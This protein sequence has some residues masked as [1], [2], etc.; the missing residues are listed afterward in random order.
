MQPVLHGFQIGECQLEL[1]DAEVFQWVG[2]PGDVV[3]LEGAEDEHDRVDLA[4]VGQELV[5]ESLTLAGALDETTDVDHLYGGMDD[6]LARRHHGQ[7][8][9]PLVRNLCHA[10]VGILRGEGVGRGECS[11][12]GERVVQR[13]LAGVGQPDESE[14]F[15]A[16]PEATERTATGGA[17]AAL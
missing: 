6:V 17:W 9:E 14:S 13:A 2:R 10:D 12:A 5:A 4:N 7:P 8:I 16:W 3:V 1:D 11:A 15:H